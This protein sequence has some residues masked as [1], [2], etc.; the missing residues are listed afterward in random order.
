MNGRQARVSRV[1]HFLREAAVAADVREL[2]DNTATAADAA[3][4]LSC[5]VA[6]IAK[7]VVFRR[8]DNDTAVVAVLCGDDRVDVGKLAAVAGGKLDKADAAFVKA[9]CGFEIGGVAPVAHIEP[10]QVLMERGLRRFSQ[11]WAA[12]GSAYTVFGAAPDGLARASGAVFA[13]FSEKK[14]H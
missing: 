12:A 11:V 10:A 2:Q 13:D 4:A 8:C 5:S 3:R 1:R 7:S 6:E 14:E 9:H